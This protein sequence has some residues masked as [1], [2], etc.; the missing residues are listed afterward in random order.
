MVAVVEFEEGLHFLDNFVFED[1]HVVGGVAVLQFLLSL[2]H[3]QI[4]LF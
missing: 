2:N 3:P 4:T 1:L